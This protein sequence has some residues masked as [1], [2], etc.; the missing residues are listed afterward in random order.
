LA[1]KIPVQRALAAFIVAVLAVVA[2][3]MLPARNEQKGPLI[4]AA[5]SLQDAL[6]AAA[7]AWEA[8]GH[9]RPVLSFGGT[10][11][12]ARQVEAGA[13]ADLFISADQEWM[14]EVAQKGKIRTRTRATFLGNSLVIV[15][16]ATKDTKLT[17]EPWRDLLRTL[18]RGRLAMADPDAVPAGRYARQALTS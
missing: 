3:V 17:L 13:P 5:A 14:N 12:L 11:A 10:P 16:L 18:R 7:N 1:R 8:Q 15:E 9:P 2:F 4:L 6:E